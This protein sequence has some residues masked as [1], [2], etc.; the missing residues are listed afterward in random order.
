VHARPAKRH[1]HPAKPV[2]H[3]SSAQPTA[4]Q[5]LQ[6]F[7]AM[8]MSQVFSQMN[9]QMATAMAQAVPCVP[10]SYWQGFIDAGSTGQILNRMV[11]VYQNHFT[12]GDVDGLLKF[13]RSPLG[14]KMTAEMPL[15]VAE[16]AKIGQQWGRERGQQMIHNLQQ[17]GTLDGQGRCPASPAGASSVTL[18]VPAPIS[19]PAHASSP[20][21]TGH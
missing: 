21:K 16:G 17:R 11:P 3:S 19:A 2:A 10:A 14:Q 15:A 13:Y 6:L 7:E 9:S 1:A 20:P 18:A 4:Q 5:V 8:H 12:A